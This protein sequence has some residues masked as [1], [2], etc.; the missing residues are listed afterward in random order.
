MR[1]NRMLIPTASALTESAGFGSSFFLIIFMMATYKIDP[2]WNILWF[3]LVLFVNLLLAVGAAYPAILFSIWLREVRAFFLSFVRVLF[4]LSPG[5]VPLSQTSSEITQ[6]LKFNPLT[7]LFEA[8][9][10]VFLYGRAPEAWELLYPLVAA[11]ILV[12]V[13]V[14]IYRGEQRQFAKVI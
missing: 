4:F 8:Y 6:I 5:L 11:F 2:T 1:F 3:P 7:G 14:P 9:R 10:S 12:A 13:F